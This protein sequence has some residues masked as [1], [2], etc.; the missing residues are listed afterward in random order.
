[1]IHFLIRQKTYALSG[2][3][4]II[5]LLSAPSVLC[6]TT[7][8]EPRNEAPE[9]KADAQEKGELSRP[10]QT[11][12][13]KQNSSWTEPERWAWSRICAHLPIDFDTRY[14]TTKT[15]YALD[16]LAH[17]SKRYLSKEFLTQILDD[18]LYASEIATSGLELVGIY[19]ENADI[20]GYQISTIRIE[21]SKI[22]GSLAIHDVKVEHRI[23]LS[24]LNLDRVEINSVSTHA[25]TISDTKASRLIIGDSQFAYL[26]LAKSQIDW[27]NLG[28]NDVNRELI[29]S[30][31]QVDQFWVMDNSI[32]KIL[33][34]DP[35][36]SILSIANTDIHDEFAMHG[37]KWSISKDGKRSILILLSVRASRFD[38]SS[39]E[40][41]NPPDL[42]DSSKIFEFSFTAGN[43][44]INPIPVL[45]RL[46]TNIYMPQIYTTLAKSYTDTGQPE[47][48]R[49]ILIFGQMVSLQHSQ[50][51]FQTAWLSM[52]KSLVG[53]GYIP[54]LGFLW[55]LLIVFAASIILMSGEQ[56]LISDYKPSNWFMWFLFSLDAVL[57]GITLD[58]KF[59]EVRFSSWH[60]YISY[61]L[62]FI[63]VLVVILVVFFVR[64]L[65]L[66]S[67]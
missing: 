11:C 20:S 52:T 16:S 13:D 58:K 54:E 37:V 56:K 49:A 15:Q 8:I 61:I 34:V 24:R 33:L 67:D 40:P 1:V 46:T 57:P 12:L 5:A 45:Q 47:T 27:V 4:L 43:W 48:A 9:S 17:D 21:H 53:F 59:E 39:D 64:R 10:S 38:L 42:P 65:F 6:Q 3:L 50:S 18:K 41:R 62:K 36:I 23:S 14:G 60:Q 63:G 2:V 66:P 44:G 55:I 7:G 35:T 22:K 25:M 32:Q 31:S 28:L 51:W 19:S 29:I 26:N 30:D